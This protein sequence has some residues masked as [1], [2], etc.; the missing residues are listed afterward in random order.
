MRPEILTIEAEALEKYYEVHYPALAPLIKQCYLNTID[1]TVKQINDDEYFVITGDIEAM[2]LRDSAFQVMH[3]VPEAARDKALEN[4]IEKIILKQ[5]QQVL[6]DPYANAFNE[7]ASG[8]GHKDKTQLNDSVWER[9]Y[10]LDSLCAPFYLSYEFW[11]A[12][13][14]TAIFNDTYYQMI[15]A[16]YQVIKTEQHHEMSPYSFE[17]FDCKETDTLPCE[18]KGNPVAYTG[19]SWSGFRPSDDRCIYGYL[20]P[21]NMMAVVALHHAQEI[22]TEIYKDEAMAEKISDLAAEI[23]SGIEK[24]GIVNHP[25][26]GKIYAYET[27]G[28]GN[29]VM[30]D[31]A[32]SPSLLALPF[33]KY[34]SKDDELY[35]NTRK[36]ILSK[37]NPYYYEGTAAKGI[38][39]P[40]T[41]DNYIWHMAISM[42]AMTSD[43]REEIMECLSYL[44]STHAGTNFMH[45]SFNK[46]NPAEYTRCWFAWS[47]STFAAL[48]MKLKKEKFFE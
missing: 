2:W 21:A 9:K 15:E 28:M 46:D 34:C 44:A 1:T 6:T 4:I 27:D 48:L 38:G 39:S 17:R 13:G 36:F 25:V 40:H 8:R 47:N 43:N 12:T 41:P 30:M 20:I 31:D 7:S 37:E 10:E 29:Y 19:M 23:Q 35:V 3:Y 33:L 5:A 11:R 14:N 32:N 26:Y 45:E 22:L 18:G 24:Y 16:A 42:Q